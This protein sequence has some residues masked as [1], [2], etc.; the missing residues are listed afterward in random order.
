MTK[1]K[2]VY[3]SLTNWALPI[4]TVILD[5]SEKINAPDFRC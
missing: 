5:L 1:K 3:I 4:W 2:F